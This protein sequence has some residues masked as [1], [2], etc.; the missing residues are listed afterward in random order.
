M[1]RAQSRLPGLTA[2]VAITS[3][4]IL[5]IAA[6]G[7]AHAQIITNGSFETRD[8][9]G[10]TVSGNV[11][12]SNDSASD[13]VVDAG[14][15][16]SDTTPNGVLSQSFPTVA[17]RQYQ[18]QFDYGVFSFTGQTQSL[19]AALFG[20]NQLLGQTVTDPTPSHDPTTFDTYS[21][22]FTADSTTTT[23]RFTDDAGNPTV[24]VDG[25][26]DNVRVTPVP[27]PTALALTGV[28]A[29]AALGGRR[30]RRLMT[31]AP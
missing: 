10:W 20:L 26:L 7:T 22:L 28:A 23:V 8:F 27:E 1:S 24:N 18:L 19:H 30:C 21:S 15:N 5:A 2:L 14:F 17:G 4:A 11:G 6:P 29:L 9:S 3:L 16:R 13:G 31:P 12:I 25:E